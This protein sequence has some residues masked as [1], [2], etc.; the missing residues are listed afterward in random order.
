MAFGKPAQF[1]GSRAGEILDQLRPPPKQDGKQFG[2]FVQYWDPPLNVPFHALY[3]EN[4][5]PN[6]VVN[7]DGTVDE[8]LAPYLRYYQHYIA[9]R[10]RFLICSAGPH[11][12][13]KEHYVAHCAACQLWDSGFVETSP[14]K[15]ENKGD[16]GRSEAFGM[17]LAI[18]DPFYEVP[19]KPGS[20]INTKTGQPWPR[21]V[22]QGSPLAPPHA[23][24]AKHPVKNFMRFVHSM[25]RAQVSLLLARRS[26]DPAAPLSINEQCLQRFGRNMFEGILQLQAV[27]SGTAKKP[28]GRTPYSLVLM[29]FL[30]FTGQEPNEA[31]QS[32]DLRK[33]CGPSTPEQQQQMLGIAPRITSQGV[34]GTVRVEDAPGRNTPAD[35]YAPAEGDDSDSDI[36]FLA[37]VRAGR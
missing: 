13:K 37:C 31:F 16:V 3:H 6:L 36:P 14:G 5:V 1:S 18:L 10:N 26:E 21:W 8:V 17:S 28:G 20:K 32:V 33:V 19:G 22:H 7:A 34:T 11:Y 24:R 4:A 23:T 27:P 15:R 12:A 35:L 2:E 30:E 9:T 29:N 25:N